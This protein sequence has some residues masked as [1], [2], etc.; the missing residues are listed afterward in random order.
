MIFLAALRKVI[1]TAVYVLLEICV[2]ALSFVVLALPIGIVYLG[3]EFFKP[4]DTAKIVVFILGF[5]ATFYVYDWL[6]SNSQ[7]MNAIARSKT[8]RLILFIGGDDFLCK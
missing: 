6:K 1:A 8:K 2:S 5:A 4:S 7:K 3:V